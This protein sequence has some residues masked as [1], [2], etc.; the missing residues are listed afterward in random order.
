MIR[1]SKLMGL[2]Y[3]LQNRSLDAQHV[4]NTTDNTEFFAKSEGWE[5]AYTSVVGDLRDLIDGE[6]DVTHEDVQSYLVDWKR[7]I[8]RWREI[9]RKT[10]FLLRVHVYQGKIE[11][12][13]TC[14]RKVKEFLE[15]NINE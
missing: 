3:E 14:I 13:E 15:E 11:A 10:P 6:G 2:T 8:N 7:T 4:H 5:Y 12:M 9:K 1:K